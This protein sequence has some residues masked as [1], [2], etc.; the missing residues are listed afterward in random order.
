MRCVIFDYICMYIL[1][2]CCLRTFRQLPPL[3]HDGACDELAPEVE[4]EKEAVTE[5]SSFS[6]GAFVSRW[7]RFKKLATGVRSKLTVNFQNK[8]KRCDTL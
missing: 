4:A 3:L 6:V 1:L 5:C 2:S 8:S 7:C